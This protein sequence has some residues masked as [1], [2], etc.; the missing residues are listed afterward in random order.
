MREKLY[1]G[2]YLKLA[3]DNFK[4]IDQI[5]NAEI[6]NGFTSAQLV[7]T[8]YG[9]I[10]KKTNYGNVNSYN[11][12]G[13]RIK[14]GKAVDDNTLYDLASNTKMYATNL[15]IE[16]LVTDAIPCAAANQ[17]GSKIKTITIANEIAEAKR[18]LRKG[19][20]LTPPP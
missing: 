7:V 10:I 17:E 18:G 5:I 9:K 19:H 16:K 12:D 20:A 15:A 8:R 1:E 6:A 3:N 4:L 14:D 13:S 2:I 11:K